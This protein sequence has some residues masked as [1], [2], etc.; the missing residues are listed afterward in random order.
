MGESNDSCRR[1]G[2]S[3]ILALTC[4]ATVEASQRQIGEPT[5]S[6][7]LKDL[8]A[9]KSPQRTHNAHCEKPNGPGLLC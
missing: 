6:R 4:G 7:W 3:L 9:A 8:H 1:E 5:I 2:E